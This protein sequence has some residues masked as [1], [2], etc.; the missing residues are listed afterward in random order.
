MR[1]A[2]AMALTA[3]GL[4]M[5][6][7]VPAAAQPL[8]FDAGLITACLDRGEERACIGVAADACM[9]ATPGGYSTVG[10]VGC[11]D[12]ELTWWDADLNTAYQALRAQERR[13]DAEHRP[14]PGMPPRPSTADALR[15]M[16][17]TWI[18][19]RDATCL[20]EEL[21]WWGGTG[22]SLAG[23][24]C[25]LHLTAERALALNSYRLEN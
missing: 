11:T 13:A 25:R 22:A 1:V 23:V 14:I 17:R 18:G 20:Y 10:M 15:D 4:S 6:A 21:Q 12:A 2:L 7:P 5:A 24:T 9:E 16:Q 3:A 8:R 19:W